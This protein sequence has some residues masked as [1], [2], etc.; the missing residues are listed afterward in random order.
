MSTASNKPASPAAIRAN[1]VFQAASHETK[2]LG[3][4]ID[5][6]QA[7]PEL[8]LTPSLLID[9]PQFDAL[10]SLDYISQSLAMLTD[11]LDDAAAHAPDDWRLEDLQSIQ[12]S[13]LAKLKSQFSEDAS[14]APDYASDGTCD[15][16]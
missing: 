13:K 2:N 3:A 11:I 10:Q 14:H 16:F 6:L 4:L 1:I 5:Q 15:F 12:K 9:K 8:M 7:H